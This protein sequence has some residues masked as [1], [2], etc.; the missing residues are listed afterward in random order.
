M[1]EGDVSIRLGLKGIPSAAEDVMVHRDI[2]LA[3]MTGARL[4]IAHISTLGSV[5][6]V[7]EA[8]ARGIKVTAEATPHHF[9]L[10]DKAVENY[11]T[12]AKMAPPLRAEL[13]RL[14]VVEGL[15]DGTIDAI[16]TDHAPHAVVDKE[17]EFDRA[18]NGIIGLET[19]LGLTLRLVDR[20]ERSAL[21][22]SSRSHSE[23]EQEHTFSGMG[24]TGAGAANLR[25]R[26]RGL[27]GGVGQRGELASG[28]ASN[29]A[30]R[31]RLNC[32]GLDETATQV[33][34]MIARWL[35]SSPSAPDS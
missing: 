29:G 16:A 17:S 21:D 23:Q 19:A 12:N 11:E 18:A 5:R 15:K 20:G 3:E 1:H 26:P 14:A 25:R 10:T 8:R 6:A 9:T 27:R 22:R 32:S 30:L 13:D 31:G 28:S 24:A 2:V 7:R 33:K 35:R 34:N 4:H